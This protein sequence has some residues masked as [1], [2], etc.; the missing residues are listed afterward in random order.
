MFRYMLP[1]EWQINIAH[2]AQ[3]DSACEIC[4]FT[5][6]LFSIAID[7]VEYCPVKIKQKISKLKLDIDYLKN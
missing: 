7:R 5:K 3:N 1:L 4:E 2:S 6:R